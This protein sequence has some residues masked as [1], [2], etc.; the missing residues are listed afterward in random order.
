MPPEPFQLRDKLLV[1]FFP[2]E[3]PREPVPHGNGIRLRGDRPSPSGGRLVA[4]PEFIVGGGGGG[5]FFRLRV[6]PGSG[7]GGHGFKERSTASASR[8]AV[9]EKAV[10][11]GRD[12]NRVVREYPGEDVRRNEAL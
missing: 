3:P 7:R 11:R 12:D 1:L 8:V 10:G 9:G 6:R 2:L 5:P 4:V